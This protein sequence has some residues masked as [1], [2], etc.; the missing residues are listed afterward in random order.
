MKHLLIIFLAIVTVVSCQKKLKDEAFLYGRLIDTCNG[1]GVANQTVQFYRNFKESSSSLVSDTETKLLDEVTTDESG[2]FYFLGENYTFK[3]TSS[4]YNHS[5][6]INKNHYL[7][8][9]DLGKGAKDEGDFYHNDLGNL[10]LNGMPIDFNVKII[11]DDYDSV[12][13]SNSFYNLNVTLTVKEND[14]FVGN[15]T[16]VKLSIKNYWKDKNDK[17]YNVYLF[18]SFYRDG[19]LIHEKSKDYFFDMCVMSDQIVYE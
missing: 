12:K 5:V 10:L 9:G 2:Y 8:T 16:A 19:E 3:N 18:F 14:Y 1:K 6:R 7:A 11:A 4:L 17:K 13:I 15:L